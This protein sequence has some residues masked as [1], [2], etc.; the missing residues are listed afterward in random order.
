MNFLIETGS[1]GP[2]PHKTTYLHISILSKCEP[3][4]PDYL[5]SLNIIKRKKSI[6]RPDDNDRLV[7]SKSEISEFPP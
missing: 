2:S 5:F 4:P 6:P 1:K 3:L 7:K